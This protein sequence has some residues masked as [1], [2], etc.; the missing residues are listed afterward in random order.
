MPAPEIMSADTIDQELADLPG[1]ARADN[2]ITRT[3]ERKGFNSAMQLANLVAYVA[4]EMNHHPD[5]WVHD[6]NKVTITTHTHVSGGVTKFD[7]KL[8]QRISSIVENSPR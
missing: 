4:N 7:I 8:A 5:I 2:A 1:W 3:W 6:Y